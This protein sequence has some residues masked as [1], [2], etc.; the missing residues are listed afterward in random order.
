MV[1]TF[2]ETIDILLMKFN[3]LEYIFFNNPEEWDTQDDNYTFSS[4]VL[5]VT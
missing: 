2:E 5:L 3:S 1:Y 4:G